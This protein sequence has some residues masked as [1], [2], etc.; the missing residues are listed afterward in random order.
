MLPGNVSVTF[1]P[2][3]LPCVM[4]W[5]VRWAERC[6]IE[7]L[8]DGDMLTD[9]ELEL[10]RCAGVRFPERIRIQ[11]KQKIPMPELWWIGQLARRSGLGFEPAGLSL[12][13]AILIRSWEGRNTRLVTHELVHTAQY[14]RLGGMEPYLRQYL[15]ECLIHG[16]RDAPMEEEAVVMTGRIFGWNS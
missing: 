5:L 12:G 2:C 4:P 14:E 3:I 11:V 1:F 8:R 16:Y 9:E 7:V 10:A 15:R 13:Y 6:Q